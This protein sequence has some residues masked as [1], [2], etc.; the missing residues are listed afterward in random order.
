[1]KGKDV[2]KTFKLAEN[3]EY[4]DSTGKVATIDIFTSGDMVLIVEREGTITK[5]TKKDKSDTKK[6]AESK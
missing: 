3:I 4:M 2:E 6:K 5:M 1:V